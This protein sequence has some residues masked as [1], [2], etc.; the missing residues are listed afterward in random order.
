[1]IATP[2]KTEVDTAEAEKMLAALSIAATDSCIICCYGGTNV[3]FPAKKNDQSC[4][5]N[6]V[7]QQALEGRDWAGVK[8]Q[9]QFP[10]ITN[11]GF[12]SDL[13]SKNNNYLFIIR[14]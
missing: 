11:L 8:K 1:M 14:F 10:K 2:V 4:D 6:E 3:Y 12:I 9:L 7:T 5:W 13:M